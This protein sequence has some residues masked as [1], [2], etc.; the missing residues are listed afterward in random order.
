MN[1]REFLATASAAVKALPKLVELP[2]MD[3]MEA[4]HILG[5]KRCWPYPSPVSLTP[6]SSARSKIWVGCNSY[7]FVTPTTGGFA[8]HPLT[9]WLHRYPQLESLGLRALLVHQENRP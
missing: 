1:R 5:C 7:P 6:I 4:R 9:P 2:G 8:I 3:L